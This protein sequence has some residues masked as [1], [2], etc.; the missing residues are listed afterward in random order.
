MSEVVDNFYLQGK[1]TNI[2]SEQ[3]YYN[4]RNYSGSDCPTEFFPAPLVGGATCIQRP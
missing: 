3:Y 1:L 4:Y 2:Y